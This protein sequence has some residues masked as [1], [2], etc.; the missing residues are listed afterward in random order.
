MTLMRRSRSG[1][2]RPDPFDLRRLFDWPD[3]WPDAFDDSEMRVEEFRE[4]NELVVR[5]EMAG[6]DPEKDVEISIADDRLHIRAE[7]REETKSEDAKGYRSEFRYGSFSRSLPL[8]A[9]ATEEDVKASYT[10]GILEIR[11]PIDG[12]R[13]EAKKIPVRRG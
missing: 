13:A 11:I 1:V 4:G 2:D 3:L 8:P 9:G 6:I 5:A 10:D 7:R 12:E